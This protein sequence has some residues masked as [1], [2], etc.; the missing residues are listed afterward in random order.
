MKITKHELRRIIQEFIEAE[1]PFD[2]ETVEDAW[3]GGDDLVLPIDH[4]KAAKSEPVTDSPETL[5]DAEPVLSK[6]SRIRNKQRY[7][8]NLARRREIFRK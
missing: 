8:R 4:S 7:L 5:P 6:E 3:A 1:D 2:V